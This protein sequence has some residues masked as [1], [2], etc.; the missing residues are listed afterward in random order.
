MGDAEFE[1]GGSV[2]WTVNHSDGESC[3]GHR[4]HGANGKDKS[5]KTDS[6]L[7]VITVTGTAFNAE[8]RDAEQCLELLLRTGA[9]QVGGPLLDGPIALRAGQRL[10]ISARE[11]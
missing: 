9:V 5:P 1:G 10:V 11:K 7:F 8:W 3:K 6:G 2:T 4:H